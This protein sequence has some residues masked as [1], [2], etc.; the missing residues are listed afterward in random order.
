M[1]ELALRG[2]VLMLMSVLTIDL[3]RIRILLAVYTHHVAIL[4][5]GMSGLASQVTFPKILNNTCGN[6][7]YF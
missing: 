7:S 3:Q 2:N 4:L 1:L 5:E 6:D